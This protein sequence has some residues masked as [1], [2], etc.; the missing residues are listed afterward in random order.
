MSAKATGYCL[1]LCKC[2][3]TLEH[4]PSEEDSSRT[5]QEMALRRVR[6]VDSDSDE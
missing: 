4:V 6:L 5:D 2:E 1:S 3:D